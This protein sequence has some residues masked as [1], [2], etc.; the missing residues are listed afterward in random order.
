MPERRQINDEYAKIAKDLIDSED[1]LE[2]I[3]TSQATIV[4]LSS[5]MKKMKDGKKVCGLCE[6]IDEKYKWGLPADFTI[7]IYEPNVRG[8]TE[9][10]MRILLF[11]ELLHIKIDY[12]DGEEKYSTNPHDIEDFRYIID[13]FG[14]HWDEVTGEEPMIFRTSVTINLDD[15]IRQNLDHLNEPRKVIE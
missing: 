10:Q 7:T 8:F 14:S 5:D 13:R 3:R 12:Q 4:I 2:Y 11:H 15:Q 1:V 6:R 9:E